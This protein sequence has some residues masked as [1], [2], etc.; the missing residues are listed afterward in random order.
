MANKNRKPRERQIGRNTTA[1]KPLIDP[2]YKNTFWT[3]LI[4]LVLIIFFI[5]NN[6]RAVPDQGSH[7]PGFSREQ[8]PPP[9][10]QVDPRLQMDTHSSKKNK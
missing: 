2:K 7:P 6:T 4:V 5:I 1:K 8:N 10:T 3:V 9:S